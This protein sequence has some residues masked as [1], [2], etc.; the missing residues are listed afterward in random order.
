MRLKSSF[1]LFSHWHLFKPLHHQTMFICL[2]LIIL[3]FAI[4]NRNERKILFRAVKMP[5]GKALGIRNWDRFY[6][7]TIT[8]NWPESQKKA[9][10]F[11]QFR[12]ICSYLP[13]LTEII[14]PLKMFTAHFTR[15]CNLWTFVCALMNHQIVW[16][17]KSTLTVF[18]NVFAFGSD[19]P[20]KIR[21]AI[22]VIDSHYSKHCENM[23][24]SCC[25]WE[26]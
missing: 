16:L 9:N 23:C 8:K 3:K 10:F 1:S 12:K 2:L 5:H 7:E 18:A 11:Q 14:W 4:I 22:I 13:M 25:G 24:C 21:P 19:F 17:C 20:A 26:N 15:K 6:R